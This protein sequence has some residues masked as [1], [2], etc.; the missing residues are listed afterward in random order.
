[1]FTLGLAHR[2]FALEC[3][4]QNN[5]GP[6]EKVQGLLALSDSKEDTGG[7]QTVPASHLYMKEWANTHKEVPAHGGNV[8]CPKDEPMLEH[9][10]KITV[11]KGN[12]RITTN[13]N[14]NTLKK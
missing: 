6:Y 12:E 10:Q 13:N 4:L 11:R 1:M 2:T 7:F 3:N 9:A 14:N 8:S 5:Y